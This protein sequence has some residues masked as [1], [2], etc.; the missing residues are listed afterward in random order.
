M[1]ARRLPS[2]LVPFARSI[3][4][5]SAV[6]GQTVVRRERRRR[7]VASFIAMAGLG[8]ALIAQV[9]A[10]AQGNGVGMTLPSCEAYQHERPRGGPFEQ[11][12]DLF[13]LS[14]YRWDEADYGRYRS[15]M[16]D[17]KRSLPSFRE[18]VTLRDWGAITE[19]TVAGLKSYTGFVNRLGEPMVNRRGPRP[20]RGAPDYSR[21][22][23]A[24]SC[25]RFTQ[26]TVNTWARG[27]PPDYG[28]E[29]PFSVP[30]A[31][32]TYEVWRALE[33]RIVSCGQQTGSPVEA[34]RDWIS[35]VVGGMEARASGEIRQ[36]QRDEGTRAGKAAGILARLAEAEGLSAADEITA[37][38]KAVEALAAAGA[39][40]G[41]ADD[42]RVAAARERVAVRLRAARTAEA[43]AWERDRPARE[44]RARQ[45]EEELAGLQRQN[46]ERE[47]QAS[48][49]RERAA[50]IEAERQAEARAQAERQAAEAEKQ[51]Q[52]DS[53][54]RA[55]DQQAREKAD[56]ES[57]ARLLR[58]EEAAAASD[59]CNK[60]AVRRQMMDAANAI[61]LSQF[62]GQKLLDLTRGRTLPAEP[63]VTRSCLFIADWSSGQRGLV[64]IT[65]RKNSF[66]DNLIEVRPF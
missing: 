29:A 58:E 62:R 5:D 33:N 18:D 11:L 22:F 40:L 49:E 15:F 16:L 6:T 26:S 66:G 27:G 36:A 44:A 42:E 2:A 45:Q 55:A 37:K 51:R 61:D 7:Q 24:L 63:N 46:R 31:N 1:N 35:A 48:G 8:M 57:T 50:R 19:K 41:Q 21:T 14:I 20:P 17:C 9:P 59:P 32:W 65:V 56:A 12:S 47:A 54:K 3:A 60:V 64:T 25:D 10:Q 4:S 23:E 38:L 34:D 43:E 53:A 28:P 30:V 39:K 52:R 13:G